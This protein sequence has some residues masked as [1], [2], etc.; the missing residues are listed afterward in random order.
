MPML[1]SSSSALSARAGGGHVAEHGRRAGRW[2][3]GARGRGA[4]PRERRRC[5]ARA[6]RALP[7][8]RRGGRGRSR[9]RAPARRAQSRT[10]SSAAVTGPSQLLDVQ[11]QGRARAVQ[12]ARG[13]RAAGERGA[14]QALRRGIVIRDD[15]QHPGEAVRGRLGGDGL[16]VVDRVDVAQLIELVDAQ[17]GSRR[18]ARWA[19]QVCSALIGT[20]CSRRPV[21]SRRPIAHQPPS[22][23][24]PRTA[25]TSAR[26]GLSSRRR[27][28]AGVTCGVSMPTSSAGARRRPRTRAA[29]RSPS[30]PPRWA[31]TSNRRRR[32]SHGPGSPS[33]TQHP[34][35]RRSRGDRP[36]V[37]CS[38][39][40]ASARRLVGRAGRASGASSRARAGAPWRSRSACVSRGSIRLTAS[41]ASCRGSSAA[42]RGRCR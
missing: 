25:S 10:A 16:G 32:G 28:S 27:S 34:P 38:E 18:R 23:A 42:C 41:P 3:R 19:A 15:L 30:P 8:R 36:S 17:A 21:G 35:R 22:A 31:T 26:R 11:Q 1:P 37:S 12:R 13:A 9:R 4:R 5:P 20:P 33:S 40:A 39:A 24:G 2:R 7:A 29:S 14:V 6:C